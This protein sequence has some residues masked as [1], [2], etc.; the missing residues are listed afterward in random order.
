MPRLHE[1]H[2]KLRHE[3]LVRHAFLVRLAHHHHRDVVII[4]ARV[5]GACRHCRS[6][7]GG[8]V[9]ARSW[10]EPRHRHAHRR[11]GRQ[12]RRVRHS[13]PVV[14]SAEEQSHHVVRWAESS[15]LG[16]TAPEAALNEDP[17]GARRSLQDPLVELP[18]AL[19]AAHHPPVVAL[20]LV[21][22]HGDQGRVCVLD[23]IAHVGVHGDKAGDGRHLTHCDNGIVCE[24][25]DHGDHLVDLPGVAPPAVVVIGAALGVVEMCDGVLARGHELDEVKEVYGHRRVALGDFGQREHGMDAPGAVDAQEDPKLLV[26]LE[27]LEAVRAVLEGAALLADDG[28]GCRPGH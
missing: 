27:V 26:Q 5:V 16:S 4:V 25:V 10:K 14:W 6:H 9:H 3:L 21:E 28:G 24:A 13:L 2:V 11:V 23:A 15:A 18:P 8:G 20:L 22:R 19:A 1:P 12:P 7:L 17:D